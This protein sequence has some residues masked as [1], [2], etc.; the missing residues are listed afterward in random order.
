MPWPSCFLQIS[1][2]LTAWC[3][4]LSLWYMASHSD[5][6]TLGTGPVL[7]DERWP[8]STVHHILGVHERAQHTFFFCSKCQLVHSFPNHSFRKVCRELHVT[9]ERRASLGKTKGSSKDDSSALVMTAPR[10]QGNL[11]TSM[12]GCLAPRR[13]RKGFKH[14]AHFPPQRIMSSSSSEDNLSN[15]LC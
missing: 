6:S 1:D 3:N 8:P 10:L 2:I 14:C 4:S 15:K 7:I 12:P 11:S 5:P 13:P 9:P